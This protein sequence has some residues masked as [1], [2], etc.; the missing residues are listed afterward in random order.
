MS[1]IRQARAL[2]KLLSVAVALVTVAELGLLKIDDQTFRVRPDL[3]AL[4]SQLPS[5]SHWTLSSS[6]PEKSRGTVANSNSNLTNSDQGLRRASDNSNMVKEKALGKSHS[7]V[8]EGK[9]GHLLLG[10]DVGKILEHGKGL[11]NIMLKAHDLSNGLLENQ[12]EVKSNINDKLQRPQADQ[13]QWQNKHEQ[14]QKQQLFQQQLSQDKQQLS[15]D[16][17]QLSQDKQPQSLT[18]K[19]EGSQQQKLQNPQKVLQRNQTNLFKEDPGVKK[20]QLPPN[21]NGQNQ[22]ANPQIQAQQKPHQNYTKEQPKLQASQQKPQTKIRQEKLVQDSHKTQEQKHQQQQQHQN[23]PQLQQKDAKT[24]PQQAQ[25]VGE[26][27]AQ[28]EQQKKLVIDAK[29]HKSKQ[30]QNTSQQQQ[31]DKNQHSQ[32]S[33]KH[34]NNSKQSQS[35]SQQK[36][37]KNPPKQIHEQQ[38]KSQTPQKTFKVKLPE[39][40]KQNSTYHAKDKASAAISKRTKKP[41]PGGGGG[42]GGAGIHGKT[43][44]VPGLPYA[45]TF[46]AR[47]RFAKWQAGQEVDRVAMAIGPDLV[48]DPDKYFI[49]RCDSGVMDGCC[50]W[51]DRVR[52]ILGGYLIANLTGESNLRFN[53][54]GYLIANLTG[55]SNP[56]F[57]RGGYLIANLTGESNPRL[58]RGGYLIANLT[59]RVFKVE[60]L[61]QG[62]DFTQ[63]YVPNRVNWSLPVSF[64]Q[65]LTNR[66]PDTQILDVVNN[67][68]FSQS[69][70][71]LDLTKAV[72]P[73]VKYVYFKGNLNFLFQLRNSKVYGSQLQWMQRV[74]WHRIH[75]V[76]FRRLFKLAPAMKSRLDNFLST[77]HDSHNAHVP[78]TQKPLVCAHV[79]VGDSIAFFKNF[80]N[81]VDF[82]SLENV[83]NFI[84]NKSIELNTRQYP[85]TKTSD[86]N[87]LP[88]LW[89]QTSVFIASDSLGVVDIARNQS[90]GSALLT[91]PGEILHVDKNE[92]FSADAK[93]SGLGKLLLEQAVL[94]TCDALMISHSGVSTQAAAVRSSHAQLFIFTENYDVKPF[95]LYC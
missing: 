50:G 25:R 65:T 45:E 19:Q 29:P 78:E 35:Q 77:A 91:V 43:D 23:S 95:R 79:R 15:Q 47:K 40:L 52:G 51:A 80:H 63:F 10:R 82:P 30:E 84:T 81:R 20:Q 90:F 24:M 93:C 31:H 74:G 76:L 87:Y 27:K 44:C 16:K 36:Q 89:K 18:K 38:Q 94:M 5:N 75:A 12:T 67:H 59:G 60:I 72:K 4:T 85:G 32:I 61:D 17:Q 71:F 28:Q 83:W 7:E 37:Y 92:A 34:L 56:R 86:L 1:N 73:S 48:P 49:Y 58:N 70:Q 54:G 33:N 64:H 22:Q 57:N 6:R 3:E 21:K 26:L 8:E 55:E 53:R 66:T 2:M 39:P 41:K 13:N 62:C 88:T 14:Q 46:S 68:K 11:N 69:L 9:T 42:G